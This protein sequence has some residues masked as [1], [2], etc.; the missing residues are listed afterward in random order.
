[1]GHV[2]AIQPTFYLSLLVSPQQGRQLLD[3]AGRPGRELD[4]RQ[5][6]SVMRPEE[7]GKAVARAQGEAVARAHGKADLYTC[8][9]PCRCLTPRVWLGSTRPRRHCVGGVLLAQWCHNTCRGT[10]PPTSVERAPNCLMTG[11]DRA[12]D[13]GAVTG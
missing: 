1:M 8:A 7:P 5:R 13:R 2:T 4:L 3:R 11:V 12:L 9:W 6:T 10:P